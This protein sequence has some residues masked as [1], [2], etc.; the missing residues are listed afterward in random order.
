MPDCALLPDWTPPDWALPL[1]DAPFPDWPP[2]PDGAAEPAW[3]P[4]PERV[5]DDGAKLAGAGVGLG[6]DEGVGSGTEAEMLPELDW[7]R[8]A[9]F[10]SCAAIWASAGAVRR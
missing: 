7:T 3:V 6:A 10:A 4:S 5:G 8:L 2:L 1:G 9:A